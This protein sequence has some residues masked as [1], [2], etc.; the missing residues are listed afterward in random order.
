MS[1]SRSF[2][3]AET[4][5]SIN[6]SGGRRQQVDAVYRALR[7]AGIEDVYNVENVVLKRDAGVLTLKKGSIGFTA[8]SSASPTPPLAN[9]ASAPNSP[10]IPSSPT[11]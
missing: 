1:R 11:S 6:V 10:P 4:R 5:E 9:C 8:P 3:I 2:S 7:E